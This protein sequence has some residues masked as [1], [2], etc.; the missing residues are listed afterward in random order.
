M[1]G[2]HPSKTGQSFTIDLSVWHDA[3][4]SGIIDEGEVSLMT[5]AM[6]FRRVG[7]WSFTGLGPL[8]GGD[9]YFVQEEAVAGWTE[10]YGKNGYIIAP[11]S[12]ARSEERRV[13]KEWRSR[14]A[15]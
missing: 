7:V 5:C 1:W 12:G 4:S 3:D 15:A 11:S 13:G 2:D 8:T 9:K 6:A 10:T 14:W